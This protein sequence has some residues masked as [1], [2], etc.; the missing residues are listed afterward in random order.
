[1]AFAMRELVSRELKIPPVPR[2]APTV[3]FV[4]LRVDTRSRLLTDVRGDVM[5]RVEPDVIDIAFTLER[6][7]VSRPSN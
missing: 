1:M 3:R 6:K 4:V 2:K 7:S 5:T